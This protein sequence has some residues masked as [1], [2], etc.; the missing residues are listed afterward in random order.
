MKIKFQQIAILFAAV[1]FQACDDTSQQKVRETVNESAPVK[2][3]DTV[4]QQVTDTQQ[5]SVSCLYAMKQAGLGLIIYA[6]DHDGANPQALTELN[7]Y[8]FSVVCPADNTPYEYKNTGAQL[9]S[10]SDVAA[11]CPVHGHRLLWNGSVEKGK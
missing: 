4:T 3:L 1:F 8:D 2:Y 7:D 5:T 9:G 6:C 11:V 10:S